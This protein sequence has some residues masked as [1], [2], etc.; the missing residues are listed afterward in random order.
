M[1]NSV[2]R[3]CIH[4]SNEYNATRAWQK[5]CSIECKNLFTIKNYIHR[6]IKQRHCKQCGTKFQPEKG[7]FNKFHCSND[8]SKKSAK[9]SRASFLKK[10]LEKNPNYHID[11]SKKSIVKNGR[12]THLSMLYKRYPDLPKSCQSCGEKRVLDVAHKPEHARNGAWRSFNNTTPEKIW[13][14]CPTCHAL[15][16]RNGYDPKTLGL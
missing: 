16:D 8:C 11:K 12:S 6:D 10:N 13:I 1:E 4:C 9:Q 7:C 2:I 14:L 15:I 3:Y 5:Y